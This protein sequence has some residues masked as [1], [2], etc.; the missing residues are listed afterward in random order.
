MKEKEMMKGLEENIGVS[1]KADEEKKKVDKNEEML[2]K[3]LSEKEGLE[4]DLNVNVT[5]LKE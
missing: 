3:V 1:G 4:R 5:L 2:Q